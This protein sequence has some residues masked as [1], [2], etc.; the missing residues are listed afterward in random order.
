MIICLR[1]K[2]TPKAVK[3]IPIKRF[4]AKSMFSVTK[5]RNFF[6][7]IIFKVSIPK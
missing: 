5:G 3:T 6:A 2:N 4:N 1:I 7:P